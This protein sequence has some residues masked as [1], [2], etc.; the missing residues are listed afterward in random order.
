MRSRLAHQL[1]EPHISTQLSRLGKA[2]VKLGLNLS[3]SQ[4]GIVPRQE[5]PRALQ[6][7][8]EQRARLPRLDLSKQPPPANVDI[9]VARALADASVNARHAMEHGGQPNGRF[10][11]F[12][13][14]ATPIA[15]AQ[16]RHR[17]FLR[18][19]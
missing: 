18:D 2:L 9:S 6:A 11:A 1:D 3:V 7:P 19:A 4:M 15:H 10:G 14:T 17:T 13:L 5:G 8:G 16:R 12:R